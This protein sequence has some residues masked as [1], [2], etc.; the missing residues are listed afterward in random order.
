[1]FRGLEKES[2]VPSIFAGIV[3]ERPDFRLCAIGIRG[4]DFWGKEDTYQ[5]LPGEINDCFKQFSS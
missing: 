4:P 2:D 3:G 5:K 1:M